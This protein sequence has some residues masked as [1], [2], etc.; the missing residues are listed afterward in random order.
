M[1]RRHNSDILLES[2]SD[3]TEATITVTEWNNL[4]RDATLPV[5]LRASEI[6]SEQLASSTSS[7]CTFCALQS[8]K[9][10]AR[11]RFESLSEPCSLRVTETWH[12]PRGGRRASGSTRPVELESPGL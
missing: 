4:N 6:A 5:T 11:G 2:V 10:R 12:G 9:S 3:P 7:N 8:L 1:T